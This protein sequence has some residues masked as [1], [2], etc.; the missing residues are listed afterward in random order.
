M[1]G[2][3]EVLTEVLFPVNG[4]YLNPPFCASSSQLHSL[5]RKEAVGGSEQ[6]LVWESLGQGARNWGVPFLTHDSSIF[7]GK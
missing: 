3:A 2:S 4:F 5:S 1:L 6:H 7:L